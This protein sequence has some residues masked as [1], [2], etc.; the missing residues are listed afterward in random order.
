[1]WNQP[2]PGAVGADALLHQARQALQAGALAAEDLLPPALAYVSRSW[3]RSLDAGL[4]AFRARPPAPLTRLEVARAT[5]RQH[6]LLAHARPIMEYLMGQTRE[7]AGM[8][9]LADAVAR[10]RHAAGCA[11][12]AP[13][14]W[15]AA[16]AEAYDPS[17]AECLPAPST[18]GFGG[19]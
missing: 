18:H 13:A 9:I 6:E 8:V 12:W 16:T 7:H 15:P 17:R 3:R 1:M 19:S 14:V 10:P 4:N 2:S 5:E 11:A